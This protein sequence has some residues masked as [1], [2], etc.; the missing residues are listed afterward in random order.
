MILFKSPLR[1]RIER[2]IIRMINQRV[3]IVLLKKDSVYNNPKEY[4]R[5]IV[6]DCEL[7]D[8]INLLEKLLNRK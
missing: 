5:L 7:R 8:R 6:K 4:S 1:K 3:D 2:E